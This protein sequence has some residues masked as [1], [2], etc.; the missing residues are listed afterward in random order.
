MNLFREILHALQYHGLSP[1]TRDGLCVIRRAA[2]ASVRRGLSQDDAIAVASGQFEDYV[3][4]DNLDEGEGDEDEGE[5]D[6]DE[7]EDDVDELVHDH[8]DDSALAS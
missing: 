5:E 1:T 4:L 7:D 8:I 6:Q 2:A 3:D